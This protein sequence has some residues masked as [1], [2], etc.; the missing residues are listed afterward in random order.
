MRKVPSWRLS[1][2]LTSDFCTAALR[3]TL[4]RYGAPEIFNTGQ[5]S[6][7]TS[8]ECTDVLKAHSI[9]ISQDGRGRCHDNIFVERLWWTVARMGLSAPLRH[10]IEQQRSLAQCC[11]WYNRRGLTRRWTGRHPTKPT[12]APW[13]KPCQWR[14]DMESQCTVD[15]WAAGST[16]LTAKPRTPMDKPWTTLAHRSA[17]D[18]QRHSAQV[19]ILQIRERQNPLSPAPALAYSSLVAVQATVTTAADSVLAALDQHSA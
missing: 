6:P 10:R 7:F 3:A 14:R 4:A 18:R 2:T 15:L 13:R 5:G 19:T 11:E 8:A 12:S 9:Q 17:A 16:R 1:N